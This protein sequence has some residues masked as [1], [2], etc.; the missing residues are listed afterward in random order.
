MPKVDTIKAVVNKRRRCNRGK[1]G[2]NGSVDAKVDAVKPPRPR[3]ELGL[4]DLVTRHNRWSWSRQSR[5][6]RDDNVDD[7]VVLDE[8]VRERT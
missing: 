1:Q 6:G 8:A 3:R 7:V 4:L 2:R 5:W